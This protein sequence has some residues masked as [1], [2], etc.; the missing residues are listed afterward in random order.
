MRE[1]VKELIH[2]EDRKNPLTDEQLSEILHCRRESITLLRNEIGVPDSR[3]RRK[4]ILMKC[5]EKLL[6]ENENISE[7][8]LTK[9]I[10]HQGFDVSRYAIREY[11][12]ELAEEHN[13]KSKNHEKE[14]MKHMGKAMEFAEPAKTIEYRGFSNIIGSE[15]SLKTC[16]QLAQAAILYPPHGLHTLILGATG[17]GKSELAAA[18]YEFAKESKVIQSNASFVVFNCA[19][20]ADNP[21]LLMAQLFGYVKGA[22]TGADANKEGLVEKANGSILFL[23]EVHR[24][25]HEGQEILFYLIDKGK[26]RRL[27]ETDKEREV[28]VT[29][30]AATT[31]NPDSMLLITFR[32]RIPMMIELPPL[33]MRSLNER[34]DIIKEFF[35]KEAYRTQVA[36]QIS[37]EALRSLLLYDCPGNIGQL[38]S[39]I[40][41][42]CARGFLNRVVLK[43]KIMEIG[44]EELP[45]NSKKGILKIQTNRPEIERLTGNADIIAYPDNKPY[46]ELIKENVY[47]L[48][49]E[50][51]QYIEQRYADLQNQDM[52]QEVINYIIGSE[53]E[54]RLEKLVKKV[55]DNVRPLEKKDLI[56]IVGIEV[57]SVV[58]KI[59][60]IAKRKLG[61]G[62]E[63]LYYVLAVHLSTTI[64]RFK[65]GKMVKNPQLS[66]IK[67][68]YKK[69][70]TV[71]KEMVNVI[72]DEFNIRLT[73]DEAGF[74]TM[75]LR[76]MT[77]EKQG[78]EEGRV[79]VVII[80]HGNVA[81][82]MADVANRLLGVNHARA[83]EM[84]LDESPEDA[85]D[86]AIDTVKDNDEG[87]GTL[88]LVDMGSLITFGEL[89]TQKTGIKTRSLT[90]TDT[91]MVIEAVRRAMLPDA[92]LDEIADTLEEKPLY[93]SRLMD[94]QQNAEKPS[95]DREG[96]IIAICITGQ[97]SAQKIKAL[98]ENATG[99]YGKK[100]RIIP[101]GALDA[102]I[103]HIIHDIQEEYEILAIVGTINPN[104]ENVDYISLQ[105]IARGQGL[106]RLKHI[107]ESKKIKQKDDIG[108]KV[109]Q[110]LKAMMQPEIMILDLMGKEKTEILSQLSGIL[111][112]NG[113][114]KENFIEGIIER[115]AL[116]STHTGKGIAIPHADP[117]YVIK[118]G[119]ALGRL[120]EPVEWDGEKVKLILM[121]A[122][123]HNC[124]AVVE[125]L[126]TFLEEKDNVHHLLRQD[127][128]NDV[129]ALLENRSGR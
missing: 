8:E 84:T 36:I 64:E 75:Y 4:P 129:I 72:E 96:V 50:I 24:L 91:V 55:E 117:S 59:I 70:F 28:Q 48:P 98:L 31:E 63:N 21:Q 27:G 79:G 67:E 25:P 111:F 68:E 95:K 47:I 51:Y 89:I 14:S 53:M 110:R 77:K 13:K 124:L 120:T 90:R 11:R 126:Y 60:R 104:I 40:Q 29:I 17:V 71:A 122:L 92:N 12:K 18:M 39:D 61:V 80:S 22:F 81:S 83:I 99:K 62:A 93:I 15:G 41:V 56:K 127:S 6:K 106:Q 82:G 73:D 7:R 1:R 20:Y 116:G 54:E 57:I 49:N 26:F 34:L 16:I 119:I 94:T 3:E 5:I 69:E 45:S 42:A 44:M 65:Q 115:E 123:D 103:H 118:P 102:N 86:R 85:L 101:I 23:D 74:I 121:L 113:Y 107:L 10:I 66:K 58:E 2:K 35:R 114:V 32:R 97:G 88:L 128:Y 46:K 30:I 52:N 9:R 112:R 37:N 125:E 76:M 38:R 108:K 105:D 43:T 19:D 87:K 100:I 78:A 33:S 109:F